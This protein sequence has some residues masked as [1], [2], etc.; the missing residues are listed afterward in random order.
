MRD[1]S[2]Q[3][4]RPGPACWVCA[5]RFQ[6]THSPQS[7]C[8]AT[9]SLAR[10]YPVRLDELGSLRSP[11]SLRFSSRALRFS[12]RALHRS[13]PLQLK[14]HLAHPAPS[15]WRATS[16]S[17]MS[18]SLGT[19]EPACGHLEGT[20]QVKNSLLP[21]SCGPPTINLS[22]GSGRA[23]QIGRRT[24][25]RA[26]GGVLRALGDPPL[27]KGGNGAGFCGQQLLFF[28]GPRT[29]LLGRTRAGRDA[30]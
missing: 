17:C 16:L 22:P 1:A 6:L 11:A 3:R 10:G 30:A 14:R 29:R 21:W 12:P 9:A 24:S 28:F 25:A 15:P 26:E 18:S 5:C 2:E 13:Q 19:S 20:L 23:E 8:T 4:A 7:S 27:W